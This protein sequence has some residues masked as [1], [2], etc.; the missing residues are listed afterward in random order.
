MSLTPGNA[1]DAHMR[2][3]RALTR[4]RVS[5]VLD[6]CV[7]RID[8]RASGL[9]LTNPRRPDLGRVHVAYADGSVCWERVTWE[10]WGR[11]EG[12][13]RSADEAEPVVG[14]AR[15]LGALAPDDIHYLNGADAGFRA[16]QADSGARPAPAAA[17]NASYAGHLK[18]F[19]GSL[20]EDPEGTVAIYSVCSGV[21]ATVAGAAASLAVPATYRASVWCVVACVIAVG[22]GLLWVWGVA[23]TTTEQPRGR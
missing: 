22:A 7:L 14:V 20:A 13:C 18:G 2:R 17:G 12:L 5:H 11:L 9:V 10:Y 4:Q 15:I 8:E 6:G 1:G 16:T 23:V 3:A 21:L 19:T